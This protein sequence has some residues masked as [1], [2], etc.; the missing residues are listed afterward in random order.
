MVSK[1]RVIITSKITIASSLLFVLAT[2]M[3]SSMVSNADA[4]PFIILLS[5][6]FFHTCFNLPAGVAVDSSGNVFVTDS[7]DDQILKFTNTGTFINA[8]GGPHPGT[9]EGKFR[10]PTGIAVDSSGHVFVADNRN[11]RIQE[12]DNDGTYLRQWGSFGTGNGQFK[13]P[14]GLAVDSSGN[15]FVGEVENDRIQKFKLASPCASGTTQ[16]KPGICLITSWGS[17][18]T[19]NGLFITPLGVAVDSSGN[20]FVAD[21]GNDRIQKFK[22]DGGFIRKWGSYGTR[23]GQFRALSGVAVDSSGNVFVSDAGND[24][25]QKFQIATPC[26]KGLTEITPGVCFVTKWGSTGTANGQFQSPR[27]IAVDSSGHVFVAD[28]YNHRIQKFTNTGG[29]IKQWGEKAP[30]G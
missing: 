22:N 23:D 24:R 2:V 5:R 28:A 18:G 9:A 17:F 11:H 6:C 26:P 4:Y 27:G 16:V 1:C 29:F 10:F 19:G 20:V 21:A 3:M 8:W 25:I 30:W 13:S 15:V 14:Y 7:G 12:F